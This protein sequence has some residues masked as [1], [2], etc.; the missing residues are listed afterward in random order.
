MISGKKTNTI[1]QKISIT[2]L[3]AVITLTQ[4]GFVFASSIN[5]E[6]LVDLTNRSRSQNGIK[7][8][9]I[10]HLLEQA[11]QNKADNML[12]Y[13]YFEH[14]SPLGLTPWDFI[15]AAGYNYTMA[16]ENLA[17][18]FQTSEGIHNA[19]MNSPSHEKNILRQDYEDIGIA[20]VKGEFD[21]KETTMVVE[22]FGKQIKKN[23]T[24]ENI[25]LKISGWLLGK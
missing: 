6:M 11:A 20:A 2:F 10:N 13:N 16:G 12:E 25:I 17:M 9:K 4:F 22:M 23:N 8:L 24:F 7:P 21:N 5:A 14:Y 18:D 1:Y 15:H 3:I 19:W